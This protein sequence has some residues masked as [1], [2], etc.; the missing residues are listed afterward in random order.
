MTGLDEFFLNQSEP[1]RSCF[2]A[3]QQLVL[4]SNPE[5]SETLKYGAPCFMLNGRPFCY[6]W[7]DKKTNSLTSMVDGKHLTHPKLEWGDGRR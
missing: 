2:L 4:S 7:K 1:N 5:I 6:L 3:M